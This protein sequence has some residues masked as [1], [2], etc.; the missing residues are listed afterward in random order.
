MLVITIQ[1]PVL[2]LVGLIGN[3][4]SGMVVVSPVPTFYR[5]FKNKSTESFD[6]FPYVVVLFSATMWVYYGILTLDVLLLTINICA[7]VVQVIFLIMFLYYAPSKSRVYTMKLILLINLGI[8]GSLLL[9]SNLFIKESKRDQITGGI[10]A[11]LAVAVFIAPLTIIRQVIRTKSVEYMPVS[12]SIFL[13]LSAVAWFSYGV[14]LGDLFVAIPNVFGFLLGVGQIIIYLMYMNH[15][16]E[17]CS[18]IGNQGTEAPADMEVPE[19][20]SNSCELAQALPPMCLSHVLG[21]GEL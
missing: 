19:A 2:T 16:K 1:N 11:S 14:L 20:K 18:K 9:I 6:S 17:R 3:L 8:F 10:C 5:I 15:D 13:T 4:I 21:F 12:L 7:C